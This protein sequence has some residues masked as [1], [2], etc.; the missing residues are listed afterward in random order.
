MRSADLVRAAPR[1]PPYVPGLQRLARGSCYPVPARR[2]GPV[3]QPARLHHLSVVAADASRRTSKHAETSAD[4]T[5]SASAPAAISATPA[6]QAGVGEPGAG[7]PRSGGSPAPGSDSCGSAARSP[8]RAHQALP[9]AQVEAGRRLVEQQQL[10][11]AHERPGQQHLLALPLGDHPEGRCGDGP[12]A[13]LGQQVV[14]PFPVL[15]RSSGA[16]RSRAPRSGR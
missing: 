11:P 3:A 12:D 1:C 8:S 16:T 15:G 13:G 5:T 7:S 10:G 9:G 6:H 14:G 2:R 4:V